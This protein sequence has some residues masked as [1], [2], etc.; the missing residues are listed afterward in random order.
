[1]AKDITK[2]S[3]VTLFPGARDG[4]APGM[5]PDAV[6]LVSEGC[7]LYAGK[8][9]GAPDVEVSAEIRGEGMLLMPAFTNAH[10]HSPMTLMRGA[11]AD[12]PL[13]DWLFR[14]IFPLEAHMTAAQA[15]AGMELAMLEHLRNGV[16][17]LNEMYMFPEVLAEAVGA[18]G[19][20]ALITNACV[21]F[22]RGREQ[23]DNALTFYREYHGSFEGR[24]HASVSIH[25]EYTSTPELVRCLVRET[26]GLDNVVHVH[27][28]ETE[29]EV[30]E[31]RKRHGKS[32]VGH[33]HSLGLFGGSAIA[34]H[35]VWV[36]EEDLDLLARDGVTVALNPIS[37]LK[38]GSGVAPV[39]RML[40]KG[41]RLAIGT[42]GAASNDSLDLFQEI[43]LTG[44]LH[45]GVNHDPTLLSPT[46]VLQ[47]AALSA[48][49]AMGFEKLGLILQG[50]QADCVLIDM[51]A[52][53]LLPV[54][55]I[56]AALVYAAK[57]ENVRMTMAQGRVLYRDGA[58]LTLDEERVKREA[59]QAAIELCEKAVP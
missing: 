11:G 23:L 37:N 58:Y 7:F 19:M 42:D 53:N 16:T 12:L 47:A 55:D 36:D 29:K 43:K 33:F 41:I 34:A 56:P 10:S 57:G 26:E 2:I 54:Y 21:D 48:A 25:A 45:K 9:E 1:L 52:A 51:N 49:G 59:R 22:G 14:V 30:G 3:G 40:E 44:I 46:A 27:A 15:K 5:V 20:R 8:R 18:A 38:L 13:Q 35:C 32:P 28:S 50:W 17:T 4:I 39:K 31:C 24:I 6:V